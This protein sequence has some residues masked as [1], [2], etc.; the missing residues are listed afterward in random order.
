MCERSCESCKGG[1]ISP[2]D[3]S[4]KLMRN[5]SEIEAVLIDNNG[6]IIRDRIPV[7]FLAR[8]N[9]LD[10]LS[11]SKIQ[12]YEQ[13]PACFYHTY[14]SD[15]GSAEDNSNFFTRFGSILH[16]VVELAAKYY[17]ESGIILDPTT[18]YN[19]VWKRHNLSDFSAYHATVNGDTW[20]NAGIISMNAYFKL[21]N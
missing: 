14:M 1:C 20:V 19:D 11:V 10:Y 3:I 16:E 21:N 13:C 6:E 5:R 9:K 2:N 15:E 8:Q 4:V 7:E 17:M 12:A 18:I